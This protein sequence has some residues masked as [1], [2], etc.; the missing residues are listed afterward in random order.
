[1]DAV[2]FA[3]LEWADWFNNRR[4][5]QPIGNIP[6]AEAEERY[7]LPSR[8]KSHWRRNSNQSA[9]GK[10]GAVQCEQRAVP[11]VAT[12]TRTENPEAIWRYVGKTGDV[13]EFAK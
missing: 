2:E 3:T 6:P 1:M 4:I 13:P 11:G 8:R 12:P 10:P 7:F 9:S 5:L